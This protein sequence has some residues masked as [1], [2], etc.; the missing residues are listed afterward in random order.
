MLCRCKKNPSRFSLIC[1]VISKLC[2]KFIYSRLETHHKLAYSFVSVLCPIPFVSKSHRN[3]IGIHLSQG[4]EQL[5]CMRHTSREWRVD[6]SSA[7]CLVFHDVLLILG[8]HLLLKSRFFLGGCFFLRLSVLDSL[9]LNL[10]VDAL[11]L[12]RAFSLKA[13]I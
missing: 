1:S 10:I 6:S 2:W 13:C 7:P 12:G 4:C 3:P 8:V 11:A 9:A 5:Q